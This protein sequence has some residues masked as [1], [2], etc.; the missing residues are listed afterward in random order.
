MHQSIS[1]IIPCSNYSGEQNRKCWLKGDRMAK[2]VAI[3]DTGDMLSAMLMMMGLGAEQGSKSP[4][5]ATR[6]VQY[7]R[8][9]LRSFF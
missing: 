5:G 7:I 4:S 2:S 3:L 6:G 8:G 9:K 1:Q